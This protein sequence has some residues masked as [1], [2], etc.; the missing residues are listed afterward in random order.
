ME[1]FDYLMEK[2]RM[3]RSII[4]VDPRI[5]ECGQTLEVCRLCPLSDLNR[6]GTETEGY[7][8][9]WIER[10]KP[11]IATAI[12]R[13][14]AEKNPPKTYA[15]VLK[16]YFPHTQFADDGTPSFCVEQIFGKLAKKPCKKKYKD[17]ACIK[18]WQQL[19]E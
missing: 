2:N 19:A 11:E 15:R 9:T 3:L 7:G 8:C 18:C 4:V 16:E 12:V 14:W 1:E 6:K 13:E 10:H 17:E 5:Y